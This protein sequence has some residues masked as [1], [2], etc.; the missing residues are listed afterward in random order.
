M[1]KQPQLLIDGDPFTYQAAFSK[2]G[3]PLEDAI[4]YI[5]GLLD[6]CL[7][8]TEPDGYQV[9]L[10]GKG[11]FR[12]DIAVTHEYKG[13]RKEVEKPAHLAD[14]RQHLVDNW[15][16]VVS[17]DEE[18]D[19]MIAIAATTYG[20]SA[21]IA[22]IDKDMLQVPCQNYNP[23]TGVLR[24]VTEEEGL[25]FFYKQILTGDRSDNIVGLYGVGPKKAEK[26]LECASTEQDFYVAVL[27]AYNGDEE[28]VIENARL[29]WLRRTVGQ[30]WEPPKW[31]DG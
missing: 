10:T 9:F 8:Y 14:L 15:G 6:E 25:H 7:F 12:N 23:R 31:S 28:R 18:A 16:A 29:L 19:D 1:T 21:I 22:S 11:N 27:H 4:D 20:P 3:E 2:E 5:D 24:Q 13:H 30:I 17:K 26:L